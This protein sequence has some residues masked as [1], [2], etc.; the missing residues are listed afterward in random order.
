MI[1]NCAS[2]EFACRHRQPGIEGN[3]RNFRQKPDE[4]IS[5]FLRD[6][7]VDRRQVW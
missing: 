1:E 7:V 2:T 4:A 3:I 6:I 5:N